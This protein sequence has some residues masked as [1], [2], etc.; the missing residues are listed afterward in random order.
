VFENGLKDEIKDSIVHH[1]KLGNLQALIELAT[2]ID[3]RI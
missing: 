3:N 1:D 2:W